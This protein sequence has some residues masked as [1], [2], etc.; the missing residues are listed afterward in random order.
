MKTNAVTATNFG[1]D[2]ISS[3]LLRITPPVMLAQLIQALY[4][5]VDSF[6]VGRFSE[7][8]L[9][10]LSVIYPIQLFITALAVGT[11]TGVNALM[12]RLY[13]QNDDNKA[14]IAGGTGIFLVAVSWI[15][16]TIFCTSIMQTF[17]R[18]SAR[19]EKAV[20]Y[21][22]EYGNI[23]VMGSLGIFLE[24]CFTK[25]HQANGNMVLPTIAQVSG[26][27]SNII[28]DPILIFGWGPF[29]KM[30]IS[31]A[32]VATV[33]GQFVAAII[34]GIQGYRKIPKI[35]EMKMYIKTIYHYGF[36]TIL[37][38]FLWVVYI[39]ALNMILAGFTDASITVLGLY[40]KLQSFFFIPMFA[41]QTSIV[42]VLSYNYTQQ[43]YD[44]CQDVIKFSAIV[45]AILM[46]IG[47]F[48]FEVIPGTL[49][50]F[51]SQ[52]QEVLSIGVPAFRIIG[53]SFYPAVL[54]ML[55][56]TFFQAIGESKQSSILALTRQIFCLIP[57]F[58]AFSKIGLE[59]TWIAFPASEIITGTIGV[60]LYVKEIKQWR[61]T[62]VERT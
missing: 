57:I 23:V 60:I 42:P 4:N 1:T 2:K 26:A 6:Y 61:K 43:S 14:N 21:A 35:H 48:C 40:Y 18:L 19:S 62:N 55:S 20:E 45:S 46:T 41:L 29:P 27:V 47:V 38:Q 3:I 10:A 31:G 54:S 58:W 30:G 5:T 22:I 28:L 16:F 56:P 51:F 53:L 12:A 44:R 15:V 34:T 49:I 37:L 33:F 9:T 7:E 50:R 59:Y 24:S 13:A 52:S 8:G 11:G 25:I 17:V 39:M 36:P 32:A